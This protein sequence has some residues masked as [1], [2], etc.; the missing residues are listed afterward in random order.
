MATDYRTSLPL[1][2]E[3]EVLVVGSGA[4]GAT[5]AIAAARTG[6]R[7]VLLERH[8]FLGGNSTLV[9][10]TFYGFYTPG[11][12]AK[13]KEGSGIGLAIVRNILRLHGCVIHATS[14]PGDGTVFSFTLPIAGEKSDGGVV[15]PDLGSLLEPMAEPAP[16]RVPEPQPEPLPQPERETPPPGP[17][18]R[19]GLRII[20]RG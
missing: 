13:T 15:L 17:S 12:A 10:D 19:R 1:L 16:E 20:R 7:T 11:S 9:L 2:C 4:A 6:A 18:D 8:G 5:A 14:E 3:A